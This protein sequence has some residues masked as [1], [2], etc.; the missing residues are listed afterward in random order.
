MPDSN[1]VSPDSIAL[2]DALAACT[3]N[4]SKTWNMLLGLFGAGERTEILLNDTAGAFFESIY[5]VLMRDFVFSVSALT[6]PT[7]TAGK[8]NLVI[9]QVCQL[10]EVIANRTLAAEVA[11][12]LEQ[13]RLRVGSLRDYRNKYVAHL[14]LERF[15]ASDDRLRFDAG[16]MEAVLH[17]IGDLLNHIDGVLRGRRTMF[18]DEAGYGGVETL[19]LACL[20]LREGRSRMTGCRLPPKESNRGKEPET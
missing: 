5:Q 1:N 4:L 18:E 2:L 15:R 19:L 17:A 16:D 12:L 7:K 6:D 14:D 3:I 10:P 9:A 11:R 13:V 20:E 8:N